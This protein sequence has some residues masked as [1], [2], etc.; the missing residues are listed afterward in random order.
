[1][2]QLLLLSEN[3]NQD[4]FHPVVDFLE[5]NLNIILSEC[6]GN[7][8]RESELYFVLDELFDVVEDESRERLLIIENEILKG[9]IETYKE[10]VISLKNK[11]RKK[12]KIL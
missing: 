11:P 10:E 1:M 4:N 7:E 12:R 8:D 6:R 3:I 2:E 9:L 5:K